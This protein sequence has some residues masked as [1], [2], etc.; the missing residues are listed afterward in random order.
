MSF[1]EQENVL[2]LKLVTLEDEEGY[3]L[4]ENSSSIENQWTTTKVETRVNQC[5]RSGFRALPNELIKE[6]YTDR[7]VL[8][9][10][11]DFDHDDRQNRISNRR[12]RPVRVETRNEDINFISTSTAPEDL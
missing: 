7:M 2:G 1:L 9:E 3:I 12:S 4:L 6:P 8:R 11:K 10:F 5:E